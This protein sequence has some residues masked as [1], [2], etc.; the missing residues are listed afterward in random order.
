[1][2]LKSDHGRHGINR[3]RSLNHRLHDEL[4]P[5]MQPIKHAE[6]QHRRARNLGII[7]SVKKAHKATMNYERGTMKADYLRFLAVFAELTSIFISSSAS[8]LRFVNL[9]S[10]TIPLS[11]RSSN[12]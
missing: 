2:R 11:V 12:Q 4:M 5:K 1:M 7:G 8:L 10:G 6:C 9:A 3:T